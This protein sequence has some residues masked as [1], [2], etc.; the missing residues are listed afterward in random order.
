MSKYLFF[1]AKKCP[2]LIFS[3]TKKVS[4]ILFSCLKSVKIFFFISKKVSKNIFLLAKKVS[5]NI[6]LTKN[7]SQTY[8]SKLKSVRYYF[9]FTFF[10]KIDRTFEN[11]YEFISNILFKIVVN[12]LIHNLSMGIVTSLRLLGP[13]QGKKV[14]SN[15]LIP[16]RRDC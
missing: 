9:F 13:C 10:F 5:K 8:F 16:S 1:L 2:K 4:Q 15:L 3:S 7:V 14:N 6:F 12:D 11:I